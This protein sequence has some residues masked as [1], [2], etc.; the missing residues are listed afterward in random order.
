MRWLFALV[1]I[2]IL[3]AGTFL[4]LNS[5]PK[6]EPSSPT[7]VVQAQTGGTVNL[8]EY[9]A[10]EAKPDRKIQFAKT[11]Q[12]ID[13]AKFD[14]VAE[15]ETSKGKVIIDLFESQAPITVNSFVFLAL[16][17]YYEGIVFHRVIPGFMAQT[18]DPTG[19]GSSGPGYK[20][21]L[22]VRPTLNYDKPGVLGMA[23][24]QD[25]NSNGS[26]F[27]ITFVP[28]PFLNQQYT[29]FGQVLEGMDAV[30][31]IAKTEGVSSP[32]SGDKRDKIVAVKIYQKAK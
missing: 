16:N 29:I 25:P 3:G 14:Y 26:Q 11:E 6:P 9:S 13:A 18:G 31:Q 21:G 2:V 20:F 1:G 8:S 12:V 30:N 15:L 23:R 5:R 32:A 24:T 7:P 27:F 4:V 19:T 28:T 22:E 10:L 17:R